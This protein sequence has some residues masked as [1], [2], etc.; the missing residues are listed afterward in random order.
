MKKRGQFP[1]NEIDL[2]F[3]KISIFSKQYKN[4]GIQKC[5]LMALMATFRI[6]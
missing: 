3:N 6:P 2:K 4:F 1:M 5:Y